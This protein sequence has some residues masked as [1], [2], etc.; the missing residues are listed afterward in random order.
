VGADA[1]QH[2]GQGQIL[3]DDLQ[4]FFVLA[5]AHHLHV[6][7]NIESGRTGQVTRSLV[8]LLD[9]KC[10]GNGLGVALVGRL[11]IIESLVVFVG[12]GDRADLGAISA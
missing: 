4:G 7:L 1:S 6:A 2:A 8:D 5:L 10:T 9:G 11:A 12:Q 3:H